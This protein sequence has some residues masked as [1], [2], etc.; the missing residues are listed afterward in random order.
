VLENIILGELPEKLQ[1]L[2]T[3][4]TA[5]VRVVIQEIKES[6][7]RNRSRFSQTPGH[8]LWK[9]RDDLSDPTAFIDELRLTRHPNVF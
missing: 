2:K 1:K 3:P 4:A 9:D 6:P 8:N 7:K 5:H